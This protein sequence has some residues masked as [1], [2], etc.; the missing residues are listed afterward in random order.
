MAILQGEHHSI[1]T[2][3]QE[4]EEE[5][6]TS[7]STAVKSLGKI[8]LLTPIKASQRALSTNFNLGCLP[9][10]RQHSCSYSHVFQ[11]FL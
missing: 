3:K 7:E 2:N 6:L 9:R 8:R 5:V 10:N 1:S 4:R 11:T